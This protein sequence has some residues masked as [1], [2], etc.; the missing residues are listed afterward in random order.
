MAVTIKQGKF[1]F[2]GERQDFVVGRSSFKLANILTYTYTGQ[3]GG[4]TPYGLAPALRWVEHNQKIFGEH[5]VLRVFL[6]TAGWDPSIDGNLNGI[7]EGGMFGSEPKDE[8]FWQVSALRTGGRPTSMHGV[9][10]LALEWFFKTSQ[11]TGV[12]F[13]LC[14][15]ATLKHNDVDVGQQTHVVRQTLAEMRRLQG[16]YPKALIIPNAINEWNA[17]SQWS[18]GEVN[19]LA[20]RCDRWKHPDG[21]THVG[22]SA[23]AGFEPEQWPGCPL[24]VDGGGGDTFHYD[25]GPEPGK[26]RAGMIHPDRGDDWWSLPNIQRLRHDARGMPIGFTE[27]MY[28]VEEEDVQRAETWYRH[29]GG[30]NHQWWRFEQFYEAWPGTIDYGIYHD[31]KGAQCNPLWPRPKTRLEEWA[32]SDGGWEPPIPPPVDPPPVD[33]PPNGDILARLIRIET[34][35]NTILQ[36]L[37]YDGPTEPPPVDPPDEPT[38]PQV[39]YMPVWEEIADDRFGSPPHAS[40]T[41]AAALFSIDQQL[42]WDGIRNPQKGLREGK[43]PY[44]GVSAA[45]AQQIIKE[46]SELSAQL[47]HFITFDPTVALGRKAIKGTWLRGRT[48]RQNFEGWYKQFM[49]LYPL[50]EQVNGVGNS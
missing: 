41:Y 49:E 20:V 46:A 18:L 35:C 8:G 19:M 15:I 39:T 38:P 31:E 37:K 42:I 30:W 48:R 44:N 16:I 21:R 11:E 34:T 10:K 47:R 5:V 27:S 40:A 25:V 9:G 29:R 22:F 32:S 45:K 17:H 4:K 12:A 33:P 36:I 1:Y 6:E 14:I 7:P 2:N 3:G 13:E 50:L 43:F 24:I 28:Y 23:P 26:F